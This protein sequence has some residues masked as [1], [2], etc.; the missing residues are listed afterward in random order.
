MKKINMI[1]NVKM[2]GGEKMKKIAI[3]AAIMF[4]ISST[5][6]ANTL[7]NPGF[8]TGAQTPWTTIGFHPR[9]VNTGYAHSGNRGLSIIAELPPELRT[10]PALPDGSDGW[11]GVY[12]NRL[13]S[14]GQTHSLTGWINTS[15]LNQFANASLQ[16]AYFDVL[17]PGYSVAPTATFD[18]APITGLGWTQASITSVEA[19]VGTMAVRYTLAMWAMRPIPNVDPRYGTG[20]AYF[21]DLD[22]DVVPEPSSLLLLGTGIIGML[23]ATKKRKKA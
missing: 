17:N 10:P 18:S 3:L 6:Y 12:Q 2:K 22:G 14:A 21:D 23:S 7:T 19:P 4:L 1:T 20:A 15:T 11:G 8:E 13:A 16:I 5:V 9:E